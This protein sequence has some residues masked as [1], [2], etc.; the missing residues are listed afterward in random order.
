YVAETTA[1]AW[2]ECQDHL[3]HLL[4]FYQDILAEAKDAAGDEKPLPA[5][6]AQGLR[7]SP[8]ADTMMIGS[9]DDVGKKLEQFCKDFHCTDFI[10]DMQ[11]PG[12][13]PAKATRSMELF[14]S[15]LMPSFGGC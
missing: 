7:N 9:P 2:D 10:M 8:I 15:E 11:F 4:T 12:L 3:W 1:Q 6:S 14:A 5:S 13:D